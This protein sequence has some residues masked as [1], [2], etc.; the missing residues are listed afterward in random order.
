[1]L[2]ATHCGVHNSGLSV[3]YSNL[4]CF[5]N[6]YIS[7]EA[8]TEQF[9]NFFCTSLQGRSVFATKQTY[10]IPLDPVCENFVFLNFAIGVVIVNFVFC[11]LIRYSQTDQ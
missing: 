5:L 7:N 9:P 10:R 2:G 6:R 11:V 1:M 4:N 3:A 8:E